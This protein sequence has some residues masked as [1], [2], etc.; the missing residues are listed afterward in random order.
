MMLHNHIKGIL[1]RLPAV[2]I[3]RQ[4]QLRRQVKLCSKPFPLDLLRLYHPVIIEADLPDADHLRLFEQAMQ[5]CH[6]GQR[7]AAALLPEDADLIRMDTTACV[8]FLIAP[9]Q[10]R[11]PFGPLKGSPHI[12]NK[13]NTL[14]T[15]I[16]AKKTRSVCVKGLIVVVCMCITKSHVSA[17]PAMTVLY[18]PVHCPGITLISSYDL[19][20]ISRS[21]E[22]EHE[23]S[24]IAKN[25]PPC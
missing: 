6:H 15:K 2:H 25:R 10:L 20:T 3:D 7:L 18:A 9:R 17:L 4:I 12:Y 8:H 16:S 13:L 21:F 22:P 5:A 14:V 24:K 19:T 11:R 1:R 23:I